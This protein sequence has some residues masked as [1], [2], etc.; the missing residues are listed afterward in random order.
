MVSVSLRQRVRRSLPKP[1]VQALVSLKY[2]GKRLPNAKAYEARVQGQRG[3]EVGG[4]STVFWTVL[5]MY[6]AAASVD[7]VN[8]GSE[9]V[10]EGHIRAGRTYSYFGNRTGQQFICEATEL[11]G[12]ASSSYDFVLSSNCL[13]HVANPMK[14]LVE[15]KRVLKPGGTLVLVLPNKASNFDHRRPFTTFEHLLAD[16]DNNTPETD[17]T[18]L[19]EILALHDLAMDPPAGDLENFRRRSLDNAN[20]RTLHH[21][22]FSPEVIA[23]MLDHVGFDVLEASTTHKDFFALAV[24]RELQG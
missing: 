13:E 15:W 6:Q 1:L 19:E 24:K 10:W 7:G 23:R 12:V 22:V 11:R 3:L 17:L 14:A 4:P 2:L 8:F 9:T 20:N 21:H 16:F 18:H 5:R